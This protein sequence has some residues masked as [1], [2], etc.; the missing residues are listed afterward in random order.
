MARKSSCG[1]NGSGCIRKRT[2]TRGGRTYIWWEA[3]FCA[4]VDKSTG[5]TIRKTIT[6]KTQAMV[7]EKLRAVT[8]DV[9]TGN[10]WSRREFALLIGATRG[11]QIIPAI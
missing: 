6:G 4:G 11:L 7:A 8:T 5:K 2:V 3:Q 9:I 10:M 1:V